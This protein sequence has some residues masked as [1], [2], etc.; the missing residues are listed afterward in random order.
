M[1]DFSSYPNTL[2]SDSMPAWAL[3]RISLTAI[4]IWTP[5]DLFSK[6]RRQPFPDSYSSMRCAPSC[7]NQYRFL[8]RLLKFLGT[9]RSAVFINK[10]PSLLIP[11]PPCC[12]QSISTLGSWLAQ[13]RSIFLFRYC[14]STYSFFSSDHIMLLQ[15]SLFCCKIRL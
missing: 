10:H 4:M 2:P 3:G 5:N 6:F 1:K 11:L 14:F 15:N 8:L 9:W 7:W 13:Y 12:L